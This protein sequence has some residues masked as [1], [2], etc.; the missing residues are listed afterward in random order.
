MVVVDPPDALDNVESVAV[1]VA[2]A[3]EPSFV[4][5]IHGVNNQDVSLPMTN[6]VSHPPR[7]E[8][9]VMR[10]AVCKDRMPYGIVREK[11][12]DFTGHL[13]DLHG[14]GMKV[15]PRQAGWN[16]T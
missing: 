14:K 7:T 1:R 10:A 15:N 13:S 3:V 2:H 4:V 5:E 16:T 12:D 6:R 11:N 9:G 8:T